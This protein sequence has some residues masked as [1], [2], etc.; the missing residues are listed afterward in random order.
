MPRAV[1]TQAIGGGTTVAVN[2][3]SSAPTRAK[4]DEDPPSAIRIG[5]LA[6]ISFLA[7]GREGLETARFAW[8]SAQATD[9]GPVRCPV[10][11]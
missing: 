11:H 1:G 4:L 9:D 7:V 2:S 10:P 3:R 8:S 5:A 6:A